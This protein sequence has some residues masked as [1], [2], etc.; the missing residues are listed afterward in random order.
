MV[1]EIFGA[2]EAL[3]LTDVPDE[4]QRALGLHLLPREILGELQHG[5]RA[6][7]VV[8]GAVG[9][10]VTP[11]RCAVCL[12]ADAGE[13]GI[14][15]R[16]SGGIR[17]R[18][19]L[20]GALHAEEMVDHVDRIVRHRAAGTDVVIVR[21]N[22][23]ELAAKLR[24]RPAQD[25]HDVPGGKLDGGLVEHQTARESGSCSTCAE[26]QRVRA[27]HRLRDGRGDVEIRRNSV[28]RL[29]PG[30]LRWLLVGF[31]GR[32]GQPVGADYRD[33]R[34]AGKSRED[35]RSARKPGDAAR[36]ALF[37]SRVENDDLAGSRTTRQQVRA[38]TPHSRVYHGHSLDRSGIAPLVARHE[39]RP[40]DE[41]AV[42]HADRRR[43]SKGAV[44][45]GNG[46]EI[47]P[48]VARRLEAEALGF[49]RDVVGALHI[50]DLAEEASSHRVV[51]ELEQTRAKVVDGDRRRRGGWLEGARSFEHAPVRALCACHA[52]GAKRRGDRR[53]RCGADGTGHEQVAW[54][55]QP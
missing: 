9:D 50:A 28:A 22:R 19:R 2:P 23:H 49:T 54:W 30:A 13:D 10:G 15:A 36:H 34:G 42:A 3:L 46:L 12:L 20:V 41:L 51:G 29:G 25:A 33:S 24:V 7:P 48:V 6:G 1:G 4:Y 17:L 37:R 38:V 43:C 5:H 53:K 47:R 11:G 45:D 39:V 44:H 32:R 35:G 18:R 40:G 14:D 26:R 27:E 8:V 52:R 16:E 31:D 21:A 55:V